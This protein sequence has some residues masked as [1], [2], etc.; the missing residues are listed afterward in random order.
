MW[1][2]VLGAIRKQVE[3]AMESKSVG[4][5]LHGLCISSCLGAEFLPWNMELGV[6][7]S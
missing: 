5:V 1:V 3:Q 4:S 7:K 6:S 2:V